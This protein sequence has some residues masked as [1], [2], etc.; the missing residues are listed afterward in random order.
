M[1]SANRRTRIRIA[2]LL[3]SACAAA[4]CIGDR[5]ESDERPTAAVS[6]AEIYRDHCAICHGP[7]GKGDGE[8]ADRFA[9]QPR[10][11]V[12]ADYR[13][14]STGSGKL[15]TD[16]DLE[17][18][19]VQGLGGTGMVPQDHL[20]A[21]EV[22]AVIEHIKNLSPRYK[23]EKTPKLMKLPAARKRTETDIKRGRSIYLEAG[24]DGC[25][26]DLGDGNGRNA[27]D[28]SLPPTDLTRHPLKGG[29]TA[30]D[31]LRAVVTGLNGTPMPS[32]HLLFD[33]DDFWALA[34]YVESLGTDQGMSEQA[35]IGWEVEKRAPPR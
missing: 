24:C 2:S 4:G 14:R 10:N 13:F 29:S 17:R 19:I 21:A 9:V 26:G 32:Y 27:T 16:A 15:A 28:L 25:H 8:A 1:R 22:A 20:S 30:A 6:G 3:V 23:E 33:D 34:Y 5:A 31:I 18:T 7:E 11:F 35:R 12:L